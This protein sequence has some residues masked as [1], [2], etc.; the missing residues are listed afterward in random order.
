MAGIDTTVEIKGLEE[1][2]KKLEKEVA[3]GP[4]LKMIL[5][6]AALRVEREAKIL[7]PFDTGRLRA[8]ITPSVSASPVPLWAKVSSN[9][10]Y[11]SYVEYGTRKWVGKAFLRPALERVRAKIDELLGKAAKMIEQRFGK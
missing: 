7:A 11:A 5:G 8:S 4:P 10:R 3:L 1:L 2:Q 6:E 9:V